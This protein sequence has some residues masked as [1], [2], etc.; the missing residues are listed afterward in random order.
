M[1]ATR[2]PGVAIALGLALALVGCAGNMRSLPSAIELEAEAY[3]D[4]SD[5]IIGPQDI[6]Q[7]SVWRQVEL[8][9]DALIVRPDGKI[10][11]PLLDDVQAAGLAPI[12]LKALLADRWGEFITAPQVTVIVRQINSKL[13][14]VLGEVAR[15][16]P[17]PIRGDFRVVDA[18]SAAGGFGAFAG[19]DRVKIIRTT[20]SLDHVEFRFNYGDFIDGKN[21]EQNIT[22]L[23]GDR[24]VVPEESPFW[25]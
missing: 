7:V 10:S 14:Y 2:P 11:V 15:Q 16:G 17:I 4:L 5:Y 23:P 13:V 24:I 25:D 22:L 20:S 18:L 9:V 1:I 6:L 3:E 8:S 19:K 21:L 12:E